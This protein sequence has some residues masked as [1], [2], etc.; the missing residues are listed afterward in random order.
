MMT[1]SGRV[2]YTPGAIVIARDL[3]G[4]AYHLCK[5]VDITRSGLYVARLYDYGKGNWTGHRKIQPWTVIRK[6]PIEQSNDENL[7][8]FA[9]NLK[10]IA[11]QRKH[12]IDDINRKMTARVRKTFEG[13]QSIIEAMTEKPY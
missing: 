8:L 6:I 12:E 3:E 2:I 10:S 5:I 11:N 7:K 4:E 1:A 13:Q 9:Y